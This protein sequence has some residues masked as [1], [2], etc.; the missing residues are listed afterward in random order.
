MPVGR[1]GFRGGIHEPETLYGDA[2][3]KRRCTI[4]V[5]KRLNKPAPRGIFRQIP[6]ES[7][8]LAVRGCRATG[9]CPYPRMVNECC[10]ENLIS[11]IKNYCWLL[12]AN[13]PHETQGECIR[14]FPIVG[15]VE[16]ANRKSRWRSASLSAFVGGAVKRG[17][18]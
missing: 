1:I 3:E 5:E 4:Q 6:A 2:G 10:L 9:Y 16:R 15:P 8:R 14:I 12:I 17:F 7:S 11:P 13:S 18:R